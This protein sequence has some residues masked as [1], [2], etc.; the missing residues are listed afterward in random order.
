MSTKDKIEKT[1]KK[2][3]KIFSISGEEIKR[4]R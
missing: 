1:I 2:S 4:K 3:R